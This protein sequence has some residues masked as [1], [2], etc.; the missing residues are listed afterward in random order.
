MKAFV[1]SVNGERICT[2]GLT[3]N[4]A[5][6]VQFAWIGGPEGQVFL[7]AGGMDDRDHVNWEMPE[8]EVGD[9]VAVKVVECE[10][11]DPPSSRRSVKEVDRWARSLRPK[12]KS[13]KDDDGELPPLPAPW[14]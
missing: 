3:P 14:E 1:I 11:P 7:H 12:G 4:N 10:E 5:R 8:L 13:G 2:I 9:E 6:S